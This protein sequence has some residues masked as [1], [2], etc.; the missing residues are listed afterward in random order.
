V[1]PL[2]RWLAEEGPG[3]RRARGLEAL[4]ATLAALQR[5]SVELPPL[6]LDQLW[7]APVADAPCEPVPAA[8]PA[9][10]WKRSPA[11]FLSGVRS[12]RIRTGARAHAGRALLHG[13]RAERLVTPE[14]EQRI[15]GLIERPPGARNALPPAS[16][17]AG[18]TPGPGI[19]SG[20]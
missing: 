4:A 20:G 19:A 16:R 2:A 13:L 6:A 11:I 14:E 7:I 15:R 8:S 5:S 9:L 3:A 12:G 18:V 1:R 17:G 10:R